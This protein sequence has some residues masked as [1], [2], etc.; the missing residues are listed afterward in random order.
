MW[1]AALGPEHPEVGRA[2]NNLAVTYQD[3]GEFDKAEPLYKRALEI[4]ENA[5]G[6]EHPEVANGLTS[7]ATLLA[8][9]SRSL[10]AKELLSRAQNI[11]MRTSGQ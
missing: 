7:Y 3:Q 1:E 11:M 5:L 2:L 6:P 4:L 9:T 8:L 10:Y